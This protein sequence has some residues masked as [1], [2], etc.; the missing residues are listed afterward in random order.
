MIIRSMPVCVFLLF[1]AVC[2]MAADG[3]PMISMPLWAQGA[4][5]DNGLS[6]PEKGG[7]CIGN[8]SKPMLE[9]YLPSKELATGAA[10]VVIPGG[11]Y[12]VVCMAS[13]GK[14]IAEL[15]LACT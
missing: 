2:G 10:V 4:P 13:E 11:G 15:R 1:W 5:D 12:G 3:P 14:S 6:G 7:G 9:V 8:I